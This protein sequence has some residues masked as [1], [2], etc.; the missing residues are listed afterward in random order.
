MVNFNNE[1]FQKY[2][3]ILLNN[4]IDVF[5]FMGNDVSIGDFSRHLRSYLAKTEKPSQRFIE[6]FKSGVTKEIE[7]QKIPPTPEHEEYF[8]KLD[9]DKYETKFIR[10]S[11]NTVIT[12][13]SFVKREYSSRLEM[14]REELENLIAFEKRWENLV[15][16]I[17]AQESNANAINEQLWAAKVK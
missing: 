11:N 16:E 2:Y 13:T 3:K 12:R 4:H 9:K 10:T 8:N 5:E 17:E 1:I 6:E 7:R 15:K 14:P